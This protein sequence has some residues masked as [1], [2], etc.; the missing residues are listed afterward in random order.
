MIRVFSPLSRFDK[1]RHIVPTAL[2]VRLQRSRKEL[3]KAEEESIDD[4]WVIL[5]TSRRVHVTIF[6][7]TT[8]RSLLCRFYPL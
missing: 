8:R 1:S 5:S 7:G 3:C 2:F 4:Y 6:S